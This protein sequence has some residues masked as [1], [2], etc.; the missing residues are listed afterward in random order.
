MGLFKFEFEFDLHTA[1]CCLANTTSHIYDLSAPTSTRSTTFSAIRMLKTLNVLHTHKMTWL[2]FF[3]VAAVNSVSPAIACPTFQE[4]LTCATFHETRS[5][6]TCP[7]FVTQEPSSHAQLFMKQEPLMPCFVHKLSL[8]SCPN[9]VHDRK[10]Y[11]LK[12]L[13]LRLSLP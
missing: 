5:I 6:L 10:F 8:F 3:G 2:C 11:G 13:S 12:R 9:R 7:T 4:L 1:L